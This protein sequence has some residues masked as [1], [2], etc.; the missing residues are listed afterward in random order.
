MSLF[1]MNVQSGYPTMNTVPPFSTLTITKAC[2]TAGSF[3]SGWLFFIDRGVSFPIC[4]LNSEENPQFD[5]DLFFLPRQ[6]IAFSITGDVSITVSGFY[7]TC[8]S[9][10]DA[11]QTEDESLEN[12]EDLS[13]Y[14]AQLNELSTLLGAPQKEEAPETHSLQSSPPNSLTI[15]HDQ[16][17]AKPHST[18]SA[19]KR[20]KRPSF[21]EQDTIIPF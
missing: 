2:V 18:S 17:D 19:S 21:S 12:G 5:L 11:D 6:N 4:C 15:S 1:S 13:S 8:Y 20:K 3:G 10:L 7:R 14:L 9:H 16:D